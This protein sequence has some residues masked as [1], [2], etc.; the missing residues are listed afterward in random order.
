MRVADFA[1]GEFKFLSFLTLYYGREWYRKN[2]S[3][4]CY[5]FFKNWYHVA[6]LIFFGS[7]S[8]YSGVM[9]YDIY[10]HEMYNTF[11]TA[12]P[13][14]VFTVFDEKF[15]FEESMQYPA[16][17]YEPGINKEY[18]NQIAYFKSIG[19]GL[20]YGFISVVTIFMFMED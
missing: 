8:F 20:I 7:Y 12:F 19:I 18:F 5:N 17:L 14:I 4:V 15:T 16:F 1:I 9:I 13:I 3:M 6:A 11:Y 10:S 2:A